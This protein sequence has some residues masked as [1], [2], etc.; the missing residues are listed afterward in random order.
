RRRFLKATNVTYETTANPPAARVFGAPKRWE[1]TPARRVPSGMVPKNERINM[2]MTRPRIRSVTSCCS[3]VLVTATDDT[4]ENPTK[5]RKKSD[6]GKYV[7]SPK[8]IKQIPNENAPPTTDQ[9]FFL[10][11]PR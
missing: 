3:S 10:K 9:P 1:N 6:R 8:P 11:S 5:K 2:L 4:M 7:E